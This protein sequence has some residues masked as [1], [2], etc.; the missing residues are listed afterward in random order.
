MVF[1]RRSHRPLTL[2]IKEFVWPSSGF[3]RAFAYLAKRVT[4][5]KA[6]P[7]SIAA[8]FAS[9]AAA[10]CFPLI[11]LHFLLSFGLAWCLRGSMVAAALGTAVGNPLT[12]PILFAA[13]Y[14]VGAII[15]GEEAANA[16]AVDQAGSELAAEEIFS[17]S[18]EH[19]WPLFTTTM[20]GATPIALATF[21]AFYLLVRW[22]AAKVQATRR[23]RLA[24]RALRGCSA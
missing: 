20:I 8:G 14:R 22:S 1:A 18:L 12:F 15:R 21:A 24:S 6:S 17:G 13:A 23:E 5:L 4:S 2:R 7:H 9:G 10:S 19:A 11:G 16:G 3:K